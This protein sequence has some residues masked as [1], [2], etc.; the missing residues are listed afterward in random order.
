MLRTARLACALA[1]GLATG[2]LVG[3]ATDHATT[4]L[5]RTQNAAASY[6]AR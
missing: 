6:P 3:A 4:A 2:I 1:L 5:V